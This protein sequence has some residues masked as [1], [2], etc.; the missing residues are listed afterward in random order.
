MDP[1]VREAAQRAHLAEAV[2][3]LNAYAIRPFDEGVALA[4]NLNVDTKRTDERVKGTFMLPHGTGKNVRVAVFTK[5]DQGKLI[6]E[7][8]GANVVGDEDLVQEVAGGKI[9]FERAIATPD[10]LPSLA[11]VARVLGP[12][13]LMPNPK[14]GT[15]VSLDDLDSAVKRAVGGEAK[16]RAQ[17]EGMVH[18]GVGKVSFGTD[19]LMDNIRASVDAILDACPARFKAKPPR[20]ITIYSSQGPGVDLDHNLWA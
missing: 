18:V 19:K 4:I 15:V 17:N 14:A 8:A 20:R 7:E 3:I 16:F 9:N 5:A 6:A 2:R 1:Q 13:Q 10:M 12:K 11:K